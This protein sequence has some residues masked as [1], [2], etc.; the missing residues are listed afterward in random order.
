VSDNELTPDL[1][2]F[3]REQKDRFEIQQCLLRY[4]R[5]IDRFDKGLMQSAYHHDAYDEH[6][7]AEGD[8]EN[9][10]AWAM[11]FH[12][13]AQHSHHHIITNS[14]VEL[15]GDTAHGETYYLFVGDNRE[16]APTLSYGRYID[17]FEKRDGQW[18]IAHRVCVIEYSGFFEMTRVPPEVRARIQVGPSTRD[19][20][21]VSYQRPLQRAAKT[22]DVQAA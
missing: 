15:D 3:M 13:N 4:T 7:V 10:C 19:A 20:R 8:P 11:N 5:G 16:G 9:F 14:T 2:A 18:A 12:D 17:R 21:D 22:S 1:I 6:G